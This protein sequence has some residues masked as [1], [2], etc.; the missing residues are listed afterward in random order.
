MKRRAGL[1]CGV[2]V[3]LAG[4]LPSVSGAGTGQRPAAH[5]LIYAQEWSLWRSR[6]SVPAGR[7]S[8]QL[9]NRGQDAHDLRIRRLNRH[10]HLVGHAQAVALTG[11]GAIRH[12][13]WHLRAGKYLIYCSLPQH[14]KRGM[15]TR[16]MVRHPEQNAPF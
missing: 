16:L 6:S 1:A 5:M 7:V 15:H 10:G 2:A 8:V 13:T 12:A 11:S 4:S 3:A 14:R 9:W